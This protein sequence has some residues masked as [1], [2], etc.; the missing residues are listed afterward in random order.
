[1]KDLIKKANLL[2][3]YLADNVFK[4][5]NRLTNWHKSNLA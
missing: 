5:R 2:I 1:M 3:Y 4:Y